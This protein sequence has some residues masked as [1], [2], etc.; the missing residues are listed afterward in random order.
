MKLFGIIGQGIKN[1]VES[2][3][4]WINNTNH[5]KYSQ[6]GRNIVMVLIIIF[7]YEL[8]K[9]LVVFESLP[10]YIQLITGVVFSIAFII[11]LVIER[12]NES[13]RKE[14][15]T[16][17]MIRAVREGIDAE[18]EKDRI[19][20]QERYDK[21]SEIEDKA[22]GLTKSLITSL[23]AEVA[24]CELLH[25]TDVWD[26]G[27][28]C[29]YYDEA[30]SSTKEG[31]FFNARIFQNMP[32]SIFPIVSYIEKCDYLY[33]PV[34]ELKKIDMAYTKEIEEN[35][36]KYFAM[37]FMKRSNGKPLGILTCSWK[38]NNGEFMPSE[39]VIRYKM[40]ITA[41]KLEAILDLEG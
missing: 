24:S 11:L 20:N 5:L 22:R 7:L 12:K 37:K 2:I 14:I 16:D 8:I 29:R 6:M 32:T 4:L 18:R 38:E 27:V 41:A 34:E 30:Y 13:L 40:K 3:V 21:T 39:E 31:V 23:N 36:Y 28:H 17:E 10:L 25:N 35:N 1:T 26:G 19:K 33:L 15:R 9:N